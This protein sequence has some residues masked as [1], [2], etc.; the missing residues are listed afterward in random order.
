MKN[1]FVFA[2]FRGRERGVF[3]VSIFFPNAH[4]YS[5]CAII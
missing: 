3:F 4:F 5:F 2:P 1:A